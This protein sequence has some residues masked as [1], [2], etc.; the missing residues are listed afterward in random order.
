MALDVTFPGL[1]TGDTFLNVRLIN[2]T[3]STVSGDQTSLNVTLNGAPLDP[4]FW[5][6][7][8]LAPGEQQT[9]AAASLDPLQAGDTIVVTNDAGQQL[10]SVTLQGQANINITN[11]SIDPSTVDPGGSV[12]A[13]FAARNVGAASGSRSW[14]VWRSYESTRAGFINQEPTGKSI[15]FS[16]APDESSTRSVSVPIRDDTEHGSIVTIGAGTNSAGV[17]VAEGDTGTTG[18]LQVTACGL[19]PD[20]VTVGEA[21]E[22]NATVENTGDTPLTGTVEWVAQSAGTVVASDDVTV[23][24]GGSDQATATWTPEAPLTSEI[25]PRVV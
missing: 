8:T 17:D 13:T 24:G 12:T 25:A 21:V 3:N 4:G 10:A 15:S 5:E 19:M 20:R 18:E 14:D 11:V 23:G 22:L 16:L 6:Y 9:N 7:G 1:E 2:N